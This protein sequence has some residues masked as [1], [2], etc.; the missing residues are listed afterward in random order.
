MKPST[1]LLSFA[2]FGLMTIGCEESPA[3][4]NKYG[5]HQ[6]YE[7]AAVKSQNKNQN[8]N[9]HQE[10]NIVDDKII[11]HPVMNPKTGQPSMYI[12]FP[13]SWKFIK[14]APLGQPAIKGPNGLT[15]TIYPPQSYMYTNSPMA[16]QSYQSS[17]V[18]VMA[19]AGVENVV[20]NVILPQGK[21]MGMTLINQY[22]LPEIAAKDRE[23]SSRLSGN[24]SQQDVFQVA[25]SEW[26]DGE[27]NK[28]LVVLHYFELRTNS[29]IN[30]GYNAELM[31]V[32]PSNFEQAKKQ[33]TYAMA[34]RVFNQDDVL[35]F[36]R[37]LSAQIHA[38]EVH[39]GKM[40]EIIAGG[41]ADRL[42]KN[43]A[44]NDYIQ[45]VNRQGYENGAHNND[46]L[47]EETNNAL[48]DVNVVVSPFDGKE[49]EVE[50]GNKT[51]WINDEGK[52][53]KSD[54]PLYD[55]NKYEDRYGVWK[56]APAKKY[57]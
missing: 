50:S 49:Y 54:D 23:Y 25:G 24:N 13:S 30:W 42:A 48:T 20:N 3:Q 56:K 46:V 31:K 1:L 51:Y 2:L 19:P 10:K 11:M 37:N 41:S 35:T 9:N 18:Q 14:G 8:K 36:Q 57:K 34:N 4:N 26:K 21:Q 53:I 32:Q 38:Q 29:S 47:A 40:R 45:N 7:A 33:Y 6:V 39:A 5:N 43:A 52:Y 27:G 44:T 28:V 16:N 22:P 17:G 15:F 55:P 12:P